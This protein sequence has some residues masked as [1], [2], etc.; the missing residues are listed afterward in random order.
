MSLI[1]STGAPRTAATIA[2]TWAGV[3]PDTYRR[4]Q[5][6]SFPASWTCDTLIPRPSNWRP[7]TVR[8][9]ASRIWLSPST[10]A[11]NVAVVGRTSSGHS[12]NL[13]KV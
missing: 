2:V 4:W 9:R 1:V 13:A 11:E 5:D 7:F 10:H 12:V 8:S 3:T 6:R